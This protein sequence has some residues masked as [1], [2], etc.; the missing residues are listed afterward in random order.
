MHNPLSRLIRLPWISLLQA[1]ALTVLI[2]TVLDILLIQLAVNPS[3]R[4]LLQILLSPGLQLATQV[5]VSFLIGALA[6]L[7][8]ERVFRRV[9][10]NAAVLWAL[11]PCLM[12]ELICKSFLP[13]PTLLI[14]PDRSSLMG[15]IL[16]VFL[17]GLPYWRRY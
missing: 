5:G 4:Q 15:L 13:V 3:L 10:I 9:P 8:L 17:R 6:V 12:L 11:V 16:G 1:A 14:D 7:I 2:V